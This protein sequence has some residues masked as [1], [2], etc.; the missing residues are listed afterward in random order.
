MGNTR[1]IE[2]SIIYPLPKRLTELTDK[3]F[4]ILNA[5]IDKDNYK[6]QST[7]PEEQS[8]LLESLLDK[9]NL[10][11]SLKSIVHH[12]CNDLIPI[13]VNSNLLNISKIDLKNERLR[14]DNIIKNLQGRLKSSHDE[15]RQRIESMISG[16]LRQRNNLK[17]VK[18]SKQKP[19]NSYIE[20]IA[21]HLY[22]LGNYQQSNIVDFIYDLYRTF[23]YENYGRLDQDE[24]LFSQLP[25][26]DQKKT[27]NAINREGKRLIFD[28]YRSTFD[29]L[30]I[31]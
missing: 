12:Y 26:K 9:Y 29:E 28:W 31:P 15:T 30:E 1:P 5:E 23:K 25:I 21:F 19:I 24:L 20:P 3:A 8:Q 14:W 7:L 17:T 27:K 4:E 10:K 11:G 13:L 6:P 16:A 18:A 2:L 22:W